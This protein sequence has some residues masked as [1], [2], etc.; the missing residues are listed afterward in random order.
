MFDVNCRARPSVP[1]VFFLS[2][3]SGSHVVQGGPRLGAVVHARGQAS[4]LSSREPPVAETSGNQIGGLISINAFTPDESF[5]RINVELMGAAC[6]PTVSWGQ[7]I[8]GLHF[9]IGVAP[10]QTHCLIQKKHLGNSLSLSCLTSKPIKT[11]KSFSAHPNHADTT[12]NCCEMQLH[13]P[14]PQ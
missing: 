14:T 8:V 12:S 2:P 6:S 9:A 13:S 11:P 5:L 4:S 10:D 7:Y 3:H 1:G